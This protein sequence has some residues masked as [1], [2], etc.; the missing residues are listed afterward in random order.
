ME[1]S[2]Y[3]I[4]AFAVLSLGYYLFSLLYPKPLPGIPFQIDA[5]KKPLGDIAELK[6]AGKE[7]R[8]TSMGM[9]EVARRLGVPVCQL[10]LTSFTTPL[11]VVND[12]R[13][14]EDILLRRQ[15]EFDRSL[16]TTHV[17]EQVIP[18]ATLSQLT[19]PDLKARKRQWSDVMNADFLRRVVAPNIHL[20][21]VDLVDL[22]KVKATQAGGKPFNVEKDFM[23]TAL[24]AI[25]VAILGSKLG[26]V[27]REI[28]KLDPTVEQ[29]RDPEHT[30][31]LETAKMVEDTMEFAN[32]VV[33][34][35]L[36]AVWPGLT[37]FFIRRSSEYKRFMRFRDHE[38]RRLMC[39][40]VERFN[41]LEI[42]NEK[43]DGEGEEHDTCAMDL[44]LRRAVMAARKSG[45]PLMN[46]ADDPAMVQE[47]LLMLLA[48]S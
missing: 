36:G 42:Q 30:R 9:F 16:L 40:A 13:E 7:T 23:H 15:R 17:F 43:G 4:A 35:G 26:V 12:Y 28:E 11:I 44:V 22:W 39:E 41:R 46:P 2:T 21:A 3:L 33:N 6:R 34:K 37:Y 32:E 24:D 25:W 5:A 38:I 45:G 27:R 8:E 47:L 19:T 18:R 1:S 20:A 48:V 10:L 29:N 14:S 31:R